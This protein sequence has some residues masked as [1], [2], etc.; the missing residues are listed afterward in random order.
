LQKKYEDVPRVGDNGAF[1]LFFFFTATYTDDS[2]DGHDGSNDC[3]FDSGQTIN[4]AFAWELG[5]SIN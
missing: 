2:T 5:R 4:G 1:G 3:T